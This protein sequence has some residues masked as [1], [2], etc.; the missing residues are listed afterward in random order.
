MLLSKWFNI[1]RFRSSRIGR[2][3]RRL[4]R[5]RPNLVVAKT[6]ILENRTL[7][8]NSGIIGVD[9]TGTSAE[10]ADQNVNVITTDYNQLAQ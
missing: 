2:P 6:E 3:R 1:Q 10:N 9:A 7:L 5:K 8:S 4:T